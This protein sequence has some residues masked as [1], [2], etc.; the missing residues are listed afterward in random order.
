MKSKD[1]KI[2]FDYLRR[3]GVLKHYLFSVLPFIEKIVRSPKVVLRLNVDLPF[4]VLNSGS[5]LSISQDSSCRNERVEIQ[6]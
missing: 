5:F 3:A 6:F 4:N 1:P 2:R